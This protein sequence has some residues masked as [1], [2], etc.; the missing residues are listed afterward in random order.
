MLTLLRMDLRL[1]ALS[2][3]T[4]WTI[5]L[6]VVAAILVMTHGNF[7][8]GLGTAAWLVLSQC[9]S[10]RAK[11]Q[12]E[13]WRTFF[14]CLVGPRVE[15]AVHLYTLS[16]AVAAGIAAAAVAG[17]SLGTALT[18]VPAATLPAILSIVAGSLVYAQTLLAISEFVPYERLIV[19]QQVAFFGVVLIIRLAMYAGLQ[20]R[21]AAVMGWL[22][23]LFVVFEAVVFLVGATW[24]RR[25]WEGGECV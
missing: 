15:T 13:Q 7:L 8:L 18:G 22:V 14:Y 2:S 17:N 1:L 21:A 9:L 5:S 24:A 23:P 11:E 12:R 6:A 20:V 3:R 25:R 16:L 10:L 4:Q 19:I